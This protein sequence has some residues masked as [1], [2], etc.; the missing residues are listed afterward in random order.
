MKSVFPKRTKSL[1]E[2]VTGRECR[3][4]LWVPMTA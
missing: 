3:N 1:T 2:I 4:C